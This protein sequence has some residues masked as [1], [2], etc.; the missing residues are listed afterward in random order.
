MKLRSDEEW[1]RAC[2]VEHA[3]CSRCKQYKHFSEFGKRLGGR[4]YRCKTCHAAVSKECRVPEKHREH[5][6]R[7]Y[8]RTRFDRLLKLVENRAAKR[9]VEYSLDRKDDALRARFDLGVCEMTG[10]PFNLENGRTFDSPSLDRKDPNKGYTSDNVRF[11]LDIMNVAMNQYGEVVL[12]DVMKTWIERRT[13]RVKA[14]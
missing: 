12:A 5:M 1:R 7:Y 10:I 4:N 13:N 9:G 11:V 3:V 8:I 6:R 2:E 14:A